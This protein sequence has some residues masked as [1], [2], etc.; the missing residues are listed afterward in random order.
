MLKSQVFP[1]IKISEPFKP[2]LNMQRLHAHEASTLFN[3]KIKL[4]KTNYATIPC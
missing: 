3:F 1:L 4:M 2:C